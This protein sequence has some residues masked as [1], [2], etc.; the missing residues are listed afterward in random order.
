MALSPESKTN[1]LFFIQKA[2]S[3]ARH[4][5]EIASL[6]TRLK[7]DVDYA[8]LLMKSISKNRL[9]LAE[10]RPTEA[11]SINGDAAAM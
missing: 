2:L 7:I 8:A 5:L 11:N 3:P 6:Q 10:L 9:D 1:A 4:V